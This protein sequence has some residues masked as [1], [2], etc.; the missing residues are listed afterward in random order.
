MALTLNYTSHAKRVV[1]DPIH[2]EM[3]MDTDM[4]MHMDMHMDKSKETKW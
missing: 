4:D 3:E 2:I 1:E